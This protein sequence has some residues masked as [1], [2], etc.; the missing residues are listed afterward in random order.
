MKTTKGHQTRPDT[1][2]AQ[3][4]G[5]T[6]RRHFG[7]AELDPRAFHLRP[8]V[9]GFLTQ[10]SK[11]A[12]EVVGDTGLCK[13][14]CQSKED[15]EYEEYSLTKDIINVLGLT[16]QQFFSA[17][18]RMLTEKCSLQIIRIMMQSQDVINEHNRLNPSAPQGYF[19]S[20]FRKFD[21]RLD[22]SAIF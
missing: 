1:R 11:G 19:F 6:K 20:H 3:F 16:K 9:A 14:S 17:C 7:F 13:K 10:L 5:D 15:E 22:V 18:G 21:G 2:Q 12:E 8:K 4:R